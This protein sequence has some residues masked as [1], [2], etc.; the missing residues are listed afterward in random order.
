MSADGSKNPR[1]SAGK[2]PLPRSAGWLPPPRWWPVL[3]NRCR[4]H[5]HIVWP[6][7][8]SVREGEGQKQPANCGTWEQLLWKSRTSGLVARGAVDGTSWFPSATQKPGSPSL[9][10]GEHVASPSSYCSFCLLRNK[11]KSLFT[12]TNR[13][14]IVGLSHWLPGPDGQ[15]I[16]WFLPGSDWL[17]S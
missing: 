4:A 12:P 8:Q 6:P 14:P 11:L 7:V 10:S 15:S 1:I 16:G 3:N 5:F 9:P 13:L 17:W 2:A